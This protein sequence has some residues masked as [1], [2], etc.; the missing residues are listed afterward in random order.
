MKFRR[1]LERHDLRRKIFEVIE[2]HLAQKG[3]MMRKGTVVDA[4]LIAAPPSTKNRAKARD[5]EMHQTKKW[6]RRNALPAKRLGRLL[7]QFER[8]KASIRSM[9]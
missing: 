1:L 8:A 5:P 9:S 3:L 7:E 2:A 4:T 6:S